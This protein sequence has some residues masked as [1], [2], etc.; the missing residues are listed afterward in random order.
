MT[1]QTARGRRWP[2]ARI[3]SA[4]RVGI[5]LTVCLALAPLPA[6][7]AADLPKIVASAPCTKAPIIDGVLG[8]DEWNEATTIKFDMPM[9]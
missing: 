4:V 6:S 8:E 2:F 3:A 7:L 5:G 1:V 9:F